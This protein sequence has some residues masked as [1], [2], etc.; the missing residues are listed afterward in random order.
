MGKASFLLI[1]QI[2]LVCAHGRAQTAEWVNF[3]A[4]GGIYAIVDGGNDLWIATDGGL[5]R[6]DKSTARSYVF[7]RSNANLPDNHI[8]SLAKD[9]SGN[10]WFGTQ[11][12]GVAK[13][14]GVSCQAFNTKN[15]GLPYDQWNT[16]IAVDTAGRIWIGSSR[17]LSIYDGKT[18]KT[19]ET[20]SP[21]YSYFAIRALLFDTGGVAWIGASWGL[22]RLAGDTLS[23]QYAGISKEI[24]ALAIDSGHSLW[25]GTY[26]YGLIKLDGQSRTVFDITNS[27][28][29][30][31][32]IYAMK[33]DSKGRLW[34]GTGKG[35]ARFDGG[36]W[37]VFNKENSGLDTDVIYALEI[38]DE[39]TIWLASR[40]D[41]IFRFDG[42]TWTKYKVGDSGLDG[43]SLSSLA[44]D[45]NTGRWM[46]C[47][48]SNRV[49]RFNGSEWQYFD[50]TNSRDMGK[51]FELRDSDSARQ[52]WAN[53]EV[54]ISYTGSSSSRAFAIR[55]P[56]RGGRMKKDNR[57]NIWEASSHGLRKFDGR[58]WMEF[59]TA[60]SPLPTDAIAR[61][62]IDDHERIWI[63]TMPA[64]EGYIGRLI[65]FDG[66]N[67]ATMY[68]CE[69]R[70]EWISS[71]E[72]DS[73]GNV[74][75]GILNS[76]AVGIDYGGGLK[77]YD[78]S[79]WQSYDIRNS[80]LPSNS[81]V[82][83]CLDG[84]QVLWIGTYAGGLARYDRQNDWKIF[85][86]GNSGLP[87]NNVEF[88]AI[89]ALNNKWLGVQDCGLAVYREGGAILTAV[90]GQ[91]ARNNTSSFRLSQNYPNPFNPRTTIDFELTSDSPV[92]L[93]IFNVEG[94]KIRTMIREMKTGQ[95]RHSIDWDGRD[96]NGAPVP[97]GVYFYQLRSRGQ[98]TS[99]KMLMLR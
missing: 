42:Q 6:F 75:I 87:G 81:V 77:K 89:D 68:T 37:T 60:N 96:E 72:I 36:R 29:P 33:F 32:T 22:G 85:D 24:F 35:L 51:Y 97:S 94:I 67:W 83:L 74:W 61:V 38:D 7:N 20:G 88:I 15:S 41:F 49:T 10:Y 48:G 3:T 4:T 65:R 55:N 5:V 90:C 93:E 52:I 86:M 50:S 8:W 13:F 63:S 18:W 58:V 69:S 17:Y 26:G 92:T 19:Y 47:W 53:A 45:S 73:S 44:L 84:K 31:N 30:D 34:V 70:F 59:N 2:I 76:A 99:R 62:A 21:I 14:N 43:A 91:K 78:G 98:Q 27:G 80:S 40:T 57:G 11:S 54:L 23:Q 95:G 64:G 25:I 12:N 71:I 79:H 82:D 46:T 28:V 1:V 56:Q 16:G 66:S 39:G 9:S